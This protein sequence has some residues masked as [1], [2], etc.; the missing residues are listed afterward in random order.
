MRSWGGGLGSTIAPR[1][2]RDENGKDCKVG[3]STSGRGSP[4][5]RGR[6][7][8]PSLPQKE[9]SGGRQNK[10]DVNKRKEYSEILRRDRTWKNVLML[11]FPIHTTGGTLWMKKK[12]LEQHWKTL[13]TK[14]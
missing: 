9:K 10:G 6:V 14:N 11:V 7:R 3:G 2:V 5:G 13:A 12:N 8:E 4:G 1:S